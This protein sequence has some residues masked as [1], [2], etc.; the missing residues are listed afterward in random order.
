MVNILYRTTD[1]DK[2][3]PG[4]DSQLTLAEGDTNFWEIS[5]E[6]EDI[7]NNPP[8]AVSIA[9]IQVVGSEMQI[10]LTNGTTQ[11]PFRLP[12]ASLR[13]RSEGYAEDVNYSR[14]DLLP[15]PELGL[16]LV[17]EDHNSGD[18]WPFNPFAVDGQG[19][20][21]YQLQYGQDTTTYDVGFSAPGTPG[22]G[23]SEGDPMVMHAFGRQ[24]HVL[25][26]DG[27]RSVARL[28]QPAGANM[29]I[30]LELQGNSIGGIHFLSGNLEGSVEWNSD[31]P[32]DVGD[33]LMAMRPANLDDDAKNL[34]VTLVLRR[35]PL[36]E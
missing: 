18:H 19:N 35:G 9:A 2:W 12:V 7:K 11:G 27:N 4:K 22:Q 24:A 26:D 15:I 13:Y 31:I 28:Q 25:Q 36:P 14:L 16:Y 34:S 8:A 3:G 33:V 5:K 20:P 21:L 10:V 29:D 6:I 23:V 17:L 32:F 30:P 1:N